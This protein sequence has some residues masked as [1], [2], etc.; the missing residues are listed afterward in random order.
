VAFRPAKM[1]KTFYRG[2][3]KARGPEKHKTVFEGTLQQTVEWTQ[4]LGKNEP[5]LRRKEKMVYKPQKRT[6]GK[7]DSDSTKY[8]S[9]EVPKKRKLTKEEPYRWRRKKTKKNSRGVRRWN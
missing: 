7:L 2:T 5:H 4:S 6:K 1:G 3:G 9:N 8:F